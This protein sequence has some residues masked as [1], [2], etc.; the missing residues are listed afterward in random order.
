MNNDD[1]KNALAVIET[2]AKK[3]ALICF[4]AKNGFPQVDLYRTEITEIAIS[5]DDDCFKI[6]NKY[7]PKREVVDRIGEAAGVIF[8]DGETRSQ[9]V[10]DL[11]C[12]KH[13][14]Y[15]GSAQGRVRMPDGT[16]RK[17][18]VAIYEFDPTLRAMLDYEV[19]E[20]NAQ[21]K[22]LRKMYYNEKTKKRER[23]AYGNTL[24]TAIMEY[25]KHGRQ[26][27][28]T[29]ARLR[30]IRE[31]VGLPVA[32]TEDQ[33]QKPVVFG[34]IVQNTS[35]ILQ[36][37]EGRIMATAMALGA[38]IPSLFGK[39]ALAD[40][41]DGIENEGKQKDNEAPP[42]G[43]SENQES[44]EPEFPDPEPEKNER[45]EEFEHLTTI[46]DEFLGEFKSALNGKSK[47]G[48]NPYELGIAELNDPNA[49]T[50]SREQ[51]IVRIRTY[52]N[53]KGINA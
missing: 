6:N 24:A 31:L 52:L 43:E 47:D 21:T 26:R 11:T 50:K 40:G 5:K 39:K 33:V 14:V 4:D 37:P 38:D 16:W 13:V 51:M 7:M 49:T 35:Y 17:S 1:N 30:V 10:D 23:S 9:T 28:N 41:G 15:T 34:R 12:G 53:K 18:S 45:N 8:E 44:N 25:Q 29:G 3:G 22:A 19:T 32:L 48:K 42:C 46:L 36:T 2:A 27:A 20:L